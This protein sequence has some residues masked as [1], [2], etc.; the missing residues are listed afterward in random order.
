MILNQP[1]LKES[2][3]EFLNLIRLYFT[4]FFYGDRMSKDK[5]QNWLLSN[6]KFMNIDDIKMLTGKARTISISSGKGG[7]GKTSIS[8]KIS[9]TLS[10]QGYKVLLI[11]C[12]Y[13]LSNIALKLGIPLN[14]HFFQYVSMKKSFDECL[15]KEGKLHLFSSCSGHLEIFKN[16]EGYS[17]YIV[18]IINKYENNYDYIILDTPAGLSKDVLTLNGYTDFRFLIVTPDKSSITD[19]YSLLK[20]LSMNYGINESHLILNKISNKLQFKRLVKSLSETAE[21]FLS[22]RLKVLGAINFENMEV[23]K[24]D[25]LLLD[26][27]AD[28]AFNKNFI[29]LT[30]KI[31][32]EHSDGFMYGHESIKLNQKRQDVW[33]IVS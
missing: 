32:D 21:S 5:T 30:K 12:D 22:C 6:N 26:Q 1:L 2:Y 23:D 28:S 19:S 8:L 7:V 9:R 31:T 33:T 29:K 4:L 20:I 14:D 11:D 27:K 25:R 10:D 3:P 15:Y 16:G 13:N 24:F 17:H 18:D